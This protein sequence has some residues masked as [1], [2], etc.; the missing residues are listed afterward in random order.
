[1]RASR[2]SWKA[3]SARGRPGD[4]VSDGAGGWLTARTVKF[5]A[6][7]VVESGTAALL[8]PYED[9][10]HSHGIAHWPA[11][12]LADAMTVNR[13]LTGSVPAVFALGTGYAVRM[14]RRRPEVYARLAT[15]AEPAPSPA[16][17]KSRTSRNAGAGVTRRARP[18]R[19]SR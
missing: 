6:D 9:C 15:P 1:M 18:G 13:T 12:E 10:P 5:F 2:P 17:P 19:R 11:D 14:R 8:Q 4:G 3:W 7:G 16:D